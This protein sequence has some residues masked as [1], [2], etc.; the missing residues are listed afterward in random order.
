MKTWDRAFLPKPTDDPERVRA[1]I[2]EW[3]YG[4][5]EGLLK[6]PLLGRACER[7]LEQAAAELQ[8]GIAFEDGGPSQQWGQFLDENGKIRPEAFTAANGG[9][10]QRLWLLPNKGA[11][12]LDVLEIDPMHEAVGHVLGDEYQLSAFAS[13]I[14]KP[15]GLKMNLHTDQWWAP[16]PTRPGRRN[17]PVGSMTRSR[18]DYDP[19]RANTSD[20]ITP[21]AC[22]NVIFMMNDFTDANG[23]TRIVPGSHLA[24]RHP[25]PERDKDIETIAAEGAAGTAIVTDG[26]VWHGTGENRTTKART[27]MLLTFC[28]PQYRPQVNFTV[29]MDKE[30]LARASDRQKAM[31]GL[32]IWWGYGRTGHPGV[33]YIDPRMP[34]DG[35]L[36]PD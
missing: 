27:A 30:I 12:F 2:D 1:D 19:A 16:E 6:E 29:A 35:E 32:K 33:E 28:G 4:L 36:R 5:F 24:G 22:S 23:G 18:F 20:M 34:G 31:F 15:G 14:A 9:I 26:R 25:D 8:R 10:N 3:G 7:L 21:A 13:N 11:V 17:L